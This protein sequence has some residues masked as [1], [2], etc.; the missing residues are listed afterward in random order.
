MLQQASFSPFDTSSKPYG[1]GR[2]P[3]GR[4]LLAYG[5]APAYTSSQNARRLLEEV[6]PGRS[7]MQAYS[8]LAY[9]ADSLG[10]P[11]TE[12]SARKRA[13]LQVY[14]GALAPAAYVAQ[15]A[16]YGAYAPNLRRLQEIMPAG[17]I[18]DATAVIYPGP[19]YGA[20]P[21]GP[22]SFGKYKARPIA[23]GGF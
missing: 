4:H 1:Y 20:H 14:E 2:G 10:L 7:L 16:S 9:A 8:P 13:L 21:S 22:Q 23:Y 15:P 5:P 17:A 19:V 12:G 3:N 6:A 11:F 18:G